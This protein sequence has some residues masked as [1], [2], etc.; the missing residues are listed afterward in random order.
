MTVIEQSNPL[1]PLCPGLCGGSH[2]LSALIRAIR[3]P[4]QQTNM[5]IDA[6]TRQ[7]II[8]ALTLGMPIGSVADYAEIAHRLNSPLWKMHRE[9]RMVSRHATSSRAKTSMSD[10]C[11]SARN[12]A[13]FEYIGPARS[14]EPRRFGT[15]TGWS[16]DQLP[17]DGEQF[18]V[19][20]E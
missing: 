12:T 17:M 14:T 9:P 7:T 5:Q 4:L 15:E 6:T 2:K 18:P 8:D 20:A 10:T 3:G 19:R 11:S 1:A 13:G 16:K